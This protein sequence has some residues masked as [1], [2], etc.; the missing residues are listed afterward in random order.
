MLPPTH[1]GYVILNADTVQLHASM[2]SDRDRTSSFIDAIKAA[3]EPG[4]VVV[5]IGT[6]TGVLA[7]AAA[8]AGAR[9]VY[10]IE[11]GP[12]SKLAREIVQR[13]DLADRI[14]V[15]RGWSNETRLPEKCDVL[16]SEIIGH[17]PLAEGVL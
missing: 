2:L 8:Q 9:H 14:T 17:E 13:N 7:I 15:I 10:A 5:D 12:I 16:V 6:G 4:D 11:A 3:V 1:E